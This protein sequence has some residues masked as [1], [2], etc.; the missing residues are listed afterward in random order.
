MDSIDTY[1]VQISSLKPSVHHAILSPG[2]KSP[3]EN[4]AWLEIQS[5]W[6]HWQHCSQGSLETQWMNKPT[7]C[8][9]LLVAAILKK[10]LKRS[11]CFC[12]QGANNNPTWKSWGGVVCLMRRERSS[13][14]DFYLPKQTKWTNSLC[15]HD[16]INKINKPTLKGNTIYI[17]S[18]CLYVADPA[19]FIA[20]NC[21][22]DLIWLWVIHFCLFDQLWDNNID[23]WSFKLSFRFIQIGNF[24]GKQRKNFVTITPSN[25]H[26]SQQ[27][28]F[29]GRL[30]P[31]I[32]VQSSLLTFR[33]H[34]ISDLSQTKWFT[35][36][37][38]C[39][40]N[41]PELSFNCNCQ[42]ETFFRLL[43]HM[44]TLAE[45]LSSF[46]ANSWQMD[47]ICLI[48]LDAQR[49]SEDRLWI[50]GHCNFPHLFW[51]LQGGLLE[52]LALKLSVWGCRE[53]RWRDFQ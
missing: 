15:F 34:S 29:L 14:T 23:N 13:L 11:G 28:E 40:C 39:H 18:L 6:Q 33:V 2:K 20:S 52:T 42:C 37:C 21:S 38:A 5:G 3:R 36:T 27:T 51:F 53:Q 31:L 17:V 25:I 30:W 43:I 48:A 44:V 16:W 47:R 19:T 35:T 45:S 9:V 1:D 4:E 24:K 22:S 10:K 8:P 50:T 7:F 12:D 49:Q 26:R 46:Y 32:F 41:K